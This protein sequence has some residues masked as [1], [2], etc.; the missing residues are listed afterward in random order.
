M[1]KHCVLLCNFCT[2]IL[3]LHFLPHLQFLPVANFRYIVN[4]C[5]HIKKIIN[6]YLKLKNYL[7]TKQSSYY[8]RKETYLGKMA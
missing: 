4:I 6:R 1:T 3:A 5:C 7:L 2:K 8:F